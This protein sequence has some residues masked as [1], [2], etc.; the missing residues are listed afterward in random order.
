MRGRLLYSLS[1]GVSA[2]SG[3][4]QSTSSLGVPT[5][6]LP[7]GFAHIAGIRELAGGNLLVS[8]GRDRTLSLVDVSRGTVRQVGREGAG[9]GEYA[10]PGILLAVTGGRTLLLD[11]GN[12]R[13]LELSPTGTITRTISPAPGDRLL[14]LAASW[15]ARGTDQAGRV[16]FEQLPGPLRPGERRAVPILRWDPGSGRL[17]TVATYAMSEA[18]QTLSPEVRQREAVIRPRAWPARPQWAVTPDGR[19][20][21]VE[22]EPYRLAT[23]LGTLRTEGPAVAYTPVRVTAEDRAEFTEALEAARASR[24]SGGGGSEPPRAPGSKPPLHKTGGQPIFPEHKPPFSGRDALRVAPNGVAWVTRTGRADSVSVDLFE[25]RGGTRIGQLSL[26]A[27][28]RV[29]GFGVGVVYLARRDADEL[30]HVERYR[31]P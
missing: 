22:P 23:L 2:S 1:F 18:M 8:D 15:D 21:L 31:L 9:P 12:A 30:E 5:L 17:D 6:R 25:T 7:H 14:A 10:Q 20:V 24:P 27:R 26:P 19:I 29:V 28:S 3:F 11:P 16:Y 4:G 13:F